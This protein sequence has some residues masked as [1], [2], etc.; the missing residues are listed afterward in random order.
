MYLEGQDTRCPYCQST[1]TE[2]VGRKYLV[3]QLR[4]CASCN[5]M[6]RWPK[7]TV[8]VNRAFY[9]RKYQESLTT[10]LPDPATVTQMKKTQFRGTQ[11]DFADKVAVLQAVV[12]AGRVLD[13]GCSWGYGTFQLQ[14]AGYQVVGF[15]IS[16]PR[17][18]FGREY[19][20]VNII[21][22]YATLDQYPPASFDVIFSSH[23]LEHLPDFTGVFERFDTLLKPDGVLL[24][25]T[26]N[27][28]GE[29]ARR[30]GVGW[31]PLINEKH[32][33]ALDLSFFAHV[34]RRYGFSVWA[35]SEPYQPGE[36]Q[37]YEFRSQAQHDPPGDELMILARRP[38]A[39]R[40]SPEDE[41]AQPLGIR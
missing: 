36:I 32:T 41:G 35:F 22:D 13:F 33:M 15:E 37:Q 18:A 11:K 26:P 23:V 14:Q 8:A 9:Q 28:G 16:Q 17:A 21:D 34:L 29:N 1:T 25:F 19:L 38:R 7:D 6:F 30:L 40:N 4:K 2:I 3:L 31:Q 10:E 5:L 27:C 20:S 39:A 12:P 24:L